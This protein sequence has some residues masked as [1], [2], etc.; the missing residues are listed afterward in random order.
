VRRRAGVLVVAAVA[1][2]AALSAAAYLAGLLPGVASHESPAARA[3]WEAVKD[4]TDPAAL[5]RF[6]IQYPGSAHAPEARAK[7]AGLLAGARQATEAER[8]AAER[9]RADAELERLRGEAEAARR[10]LAAETARQKADAERAVAGERTKAQADLDRLRAEAQAK[11]RAAAQAQAAADAA[12]LKTEAEAAREKA[13]AE[14]ARARSEAEAARQRTETEVAQRRAEA[15]A[16]RLQAESER[17]KAAEERAAAARARAETEAAKAASGAPLAGGTAGGPSVAIAPA[18]SP[19]EPPLGR[20]SRFD[21]TWRGEVT[22][23]AWRDMP[24]TSRARRF[25]VS[26]G[27]MI[28]D[29]GV[30]GQPSSWKVTGRIREDDTI[31]LRGPGISRAGKPFD[32]VVTGRFTT[33][34]FSGETVGPVRPCSVKLTRA[35]S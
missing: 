14:L 12:R 30:Q 9:A 35:G 17:R 18:V 11:E 6:V 32:Q 16:A 31:E 1:A 8:L 2:A 27:E 28:V 13:E 4:S 22:C 23:P 26:K 19:Q 7:G 29:V 5:E 3:A 24:A 21:G 15:E 34:A 20:E 10:Q 25:S 33:N